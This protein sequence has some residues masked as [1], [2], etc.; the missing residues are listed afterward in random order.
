VFSSNSGYFIDYGLFSFCKCINKKFKLNNN[1]IKNQTNWA[2]NCKK[3]RPAGWGYDVVY[4][5]HFWS[6][7]LRGFDCLFTVFV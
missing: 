4:F 3:L 5:I 1:A 6:R 7:S 2:I